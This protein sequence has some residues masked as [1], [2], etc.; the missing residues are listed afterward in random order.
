MARRNDYFLGETLSEQER[1]VAQAAGFEHEARWL[2]DRIGIQP[3]WRA[4]DVGCGPIGI[5]SLLAERVGKDGT[6][7]GLEREPRFAEMARAIVAERGLSN[8]QVVQADAHASG[9]ERESFDFV[10]GRLVLILRPKPESLLA[11]MVA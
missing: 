2:L 1:L 3:G 4:V 11:E 10:H 9:L 7:V 6:V 5:L 8:V